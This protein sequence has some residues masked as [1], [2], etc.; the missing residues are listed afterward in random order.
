[1]HFRFLPAA[2]ANVPNTSV[3]GLHYVLIYVSYNEIL[4]LLYLF[5]LVQQNSHL[6]C[7]R[8]H[9]AELDDNNILQPRHLVVC[10]LRGMH[11]SVSNQN[12][13]I[14]RLHILK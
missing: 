11:D 4:F 13:S 5:K 10:S 6:S 3:R 9:M 2:L 12:L 14:L 8:H 7:E 1:V